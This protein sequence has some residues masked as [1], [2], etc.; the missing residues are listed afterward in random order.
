M[1]SK[2]KIFIESD[3]VSVFEK[4]TPVIDASI[5]INNGCCFLQDK[6]QKSGRQ[7]SNINFKNTLETVDTI[8]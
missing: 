6:K 3:S 2:V 1:Y 5:F 4:P 8:I 7:K